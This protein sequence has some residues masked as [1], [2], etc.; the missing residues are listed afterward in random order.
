MV[1]RHQYLPPFQMKSFGEHNHHL[2]IRCSMEGHKGGMVAFRVKKLCCGIDSRG[3]PGP[4]CQTV[5]KILQFLT[6]LSCASN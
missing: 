1:K 2:K 4:A 3:I 6:L 5:L